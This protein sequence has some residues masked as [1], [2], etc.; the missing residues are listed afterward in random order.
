MAPG[1]TEFLIATTYGVFMT[2]GAYLVQAG[3]Y[4]WQSFL[5]SLPVALFISNVLLINQFPDADS[6]AKSE[7]K[8]LVVR[9]G[10]KASYLGASILLVVWVWNYIEHNRKAMNDVRLAFR[11]Q[12]STKA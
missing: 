8:T 4:S 12:S 6:D 11:N 10:K 5:I 1:I 3:A 7:K 2:M 9:V